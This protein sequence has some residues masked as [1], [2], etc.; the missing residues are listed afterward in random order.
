MSPTSPLSQSHPR[1]AIAAA[2]L[3]AAAA[4]PAIAAEPKPLEVLY[5]TGGCCHDYDAQKKLLVPALESRGMKVTVIHEGGSSTNHKVSLYEKPDWSKGYDVVF[6]NE[7]FA[8]V[9]D[10]AFLGKIVAE[11]EKGTPAVMMHCAMHCYRAGID[12][13]FRLCGVTS[14]GHGAHYEYT[15]KTL[16]AAEGHP[17]LAGLPA[18]WALPKEE[19]YFIDKLW[20]TATPLVEAMSRERKSMQTVIWTNQFGKARVFATTIGH[21]PHTVALPEFLELVTRGTLWAAGRLED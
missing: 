1:L 11:H 20:P 13:W 21:Y 17:V 19:L 4:W 7:C 15:A 16:P 2:V 9:K 5:I 14:P 3:L 6:H 18:E 12:D 10:K 8:N